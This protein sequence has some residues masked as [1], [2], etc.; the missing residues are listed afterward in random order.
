MPTVE[1]EEFQASEE[2]QFHSFCQE[3][4]MKRI[5]LFVLAVGLLMT[6]YSSGGDAPK[7]DLKKL[8]GVY[9]MVS[10]EEKGEK[11]SDKIVNGASLTITGDKHTVKVGDKTIIGTHKLDPTKKPKEIDAMDTEGPFKGKTL[12]GIY[13]LE[14]GEFT[15]CF[16][17]PGKD[18]PKEFTTK[19]GTGELVHVWK[20]K[21]D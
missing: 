4:A 19:S 13:K 12:L 7:K 6:A 3:V 10:G 15:V 16:A 9:V 14:K 18:R 1:N 20:R 11:L 5:V 2:D 21:K 17:G 8:E